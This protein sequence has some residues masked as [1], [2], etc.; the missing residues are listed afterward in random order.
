MFGIR[1][2]VQEAHD[3]QQPLR[4]YDWAVLVVVAATMLLMATESLHG[5]ASKWVILASTVIMF[6]MRLLKLRD[7]KSINFNLLVW[8]TAAF[9]IGGVMRASGTADVIFSRLATLFPSEFGLPF[10]LIVVLITMVLHMVLGSSVTTTSVVVPGIVSIAAG[11]MPTTMLV[12]IIYVLV[13]NHFLLPLHNAVLVIG[14]GDKRFQSST[15][16]QYG[17]ALTVVVPL[18]ALFIYRY[19]WQ[20]LQLF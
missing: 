9:S 8:L 17:A 12:M 7:I 18:F 15:V 13:Y 1:F 14:N 6:A 2:S 4:A 10:L 11:K 5:I 20:L 16:T 19:W 3:S